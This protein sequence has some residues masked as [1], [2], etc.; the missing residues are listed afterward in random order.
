VGQRLCCVCAAL[1]LLLKAGSGEAQLFGQWSWDA[2]VGYEQRSF[3][4]EI[5]GEQMSDYGERSFHLGLGVNGF[6]VHPAIA[7]FRIDLDTLF[8]QFSGRLNPDSRRWSLRSRLSLFP[9]GPYPS[10]YY[11]SHSRF[12]YVSGGDDPL[13]T[14]GMADTSSSWGAR[15]RMRSGPLR[16]LSLGLEENSTSFLEPGLKDEIFSRQHLDWAG[17]GERLSHHY[18]LERQYRRYGR[19]RYET[20]DTTL[21]VDEHGDLSP[22]WRWDL[23][24]LA[25]AR[26]YNY[27]AEANSVNSARIRSRW[28][29]TTPRDDLLDLSCTGGLSESSNSSRMSSGSFLARYVWYGGSNLQIIPNIGYTVQKSG[30]AD[31]RSPGAGLALSWAHTA[32]IFDIGLN[33][34]LSASWIE[35][36]DQGGREN[37]DLIGWNA[38]VSIGCGSEEKLRT[39]IEIALIHNKLRSIGEGIPG[40]P[41]N[42]AGMERIGVQDAFRARLSLARRIRRW[43]LTLFGEIR[44]RKQEAFQ[45]DPVSVDSSLFDFTVTGPKTGMTLNAGSTEARSQDE[46][47]V[48]FFAASLHYRP[49]GGLSL[50]LGFLDNNRMLRDAPDVDRRRVEVAAQWVYGRVASALSWW[51]QEEVLSSRFRENRGF[52]FSISTR[53]DGWLPFLSAPQRRGVIR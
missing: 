46:Q 35:V 14:T 42:G 10:H 32:G 25:F 36:E 34:G 21:T 47:K 37:T 30:D 33:G 8:S 3:Q 48:D 19:R 38:G 28:I 27:D 12:D 2:L 17:A 49:T 15:L 29:W 26:N 6:I 51:R 23:S 44:N 50:R 22:S 24:G 41:D 1:M 53:F 18:R 39:G 52:S 40:L 16:G 5:E 45:T 43:R 7:E 13:V 11:Y 9:H 31:L 4:T 20:E